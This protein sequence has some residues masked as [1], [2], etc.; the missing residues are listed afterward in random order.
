MLELERISKRY[1]NGARDIEVLRDVSLELHERE[2]IA[3]WGARRSGR[4]TLLRIAAGVEAPDVGTVRFAGR[5][6]ALGGGA[7]AGGIAYCAPAARSLEG[8]LVLEELIAAQLALGTR[9]SGAR[10]RA[11]GALERAGAFD[12][13]A[14]RPHEL[15]SAEAARV[16]IARA[17][18]Q[19]PSLLVIDEPTTGV[20]AQERDRILELLR[21]L[22][23]DGI[24]ILMSLDKGIG[25]FAADRALAVGEGRLRGHVAPELAP[26]V[27]LPLRLSG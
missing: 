7:V 24:A 2:V 13:Q 8:Q 11:V 1:R 12:C 21:S 27:E 23:K 15:D 26:I 25:L 10:A 4:S 9:P 22:S 20:E 16:A 5:H 18:L 6:L 14:R 19:E 3:V 17:L